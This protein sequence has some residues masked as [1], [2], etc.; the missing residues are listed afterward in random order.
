[1]YGVNGTPGTPTTSSPTL[2]WSTTYW[3][4]LFL[5]DSSRHCPD[6]IA[7]YA[8]LVV[9]LPRA[10][11]SPPRPKGNTDIC[12]PPFMRCVAAVGDIRLAVLP[13]ANGMGGP[14]FVSRGAHC[15]SG[16]GRDRPLQL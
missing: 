15:G 3:A 2:N 7:A 16:C 13:A 4:D 10:C 9:I 12:R 14:D 1:M 6:V 5:A 8:A 11:A